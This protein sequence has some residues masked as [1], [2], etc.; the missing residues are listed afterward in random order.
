MPIVLNLKKFKAIMN[1]LFTKSTKKVTSSP[2]HR[3]TNIS[4]TSG[5]SQ[6]S[7]IEAAMINAEVKSAEM[8]YKKKFSMSP[9]LSSS[10]KD[11]IMAG[12]RQDINYFESNKRTNPLH[13]DDY[14]LNDD[15]NP[16]VIVKNSK[17]TL[18]YVQEYAIR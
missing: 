18:N 16:E 4:W 3:P 11:L 15:P 2:V 17:Q 9:S 1:D 8:N 12:G 14:V 10:P 6:I 5:L 13:I 7:A